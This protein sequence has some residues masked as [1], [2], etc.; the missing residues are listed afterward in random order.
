ML[1]IAYSLTI[2]TLIE[3]TKFIFQQEFD[4]LDDGEVHYTLG[5]AILHNNKKGWTILHQKW[6]LISK[7]QKNHMFNCNSLSTPMQP[8]TWLNKHDFLN[9][10]T[11]QVIVDIYP[12][13]N[14][15]G[16]LMH[17]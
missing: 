1:M 8:K 7:L 9:T 4:M 2:L 15:V 5:N 3:Q 17:S 6:Y 14:I 11:M 13:S 16:N 10:P 12:H